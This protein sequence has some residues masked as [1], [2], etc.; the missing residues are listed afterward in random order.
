M[1]IYALK[2][3]GFDHPLG[4]RC[5]Q[6][7]LSWKVRGAKGTRPVSAVAEVSEHPDFADICCRVE[8][9]ASLG[10][11]LPVKPNPT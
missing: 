4:M 9:A 5:D 7:V 8:N 2:I 6:V 11:M 3:N 1:E 10:T